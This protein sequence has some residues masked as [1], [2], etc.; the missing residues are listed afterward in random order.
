MKRR[1]Y[2]VGFHQEHI[3]TNVYVIFTAIF[4]VCKIKLNLENSGLKGNFFHDN[5]IELSLYFILAS[6]KFGVGLV[7]YT[8]QKRGTGPHP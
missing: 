5:W 6:K 2:K 1:R 4:G 3:F 8:D 7:L